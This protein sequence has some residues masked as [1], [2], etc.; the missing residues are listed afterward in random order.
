MS[1]RHGVVTE[2]APGVTTNYTFYG[3]PGALDDAMYA[4]SLDCVLATSRSISARC[5][6]HRRDAKLIETYG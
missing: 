2:S 6:Q 1:G 3:E 4:D 5:R